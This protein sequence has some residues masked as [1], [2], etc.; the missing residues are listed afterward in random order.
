MTGSSSGGGDSDALQRQ[1]ASMRDQLQSQSKLFS[2]QMENGRKREEELRQQL[3]K[4]RQDSNKELGELRG[5]LARALENE[6]A[7]KV[8]SPQRTTTTSQSSRSFT[9]LS[10][11]SGL[12]L[13]GGPTRQVHGAAPPGVWVATDQHDPLPVSV[14]DAGM[15]V[16]PVGP[17]LKPG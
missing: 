1:L 2:D 16:P 10:A 4:I 7:Y 11:D 14:C 13:A 9:L 5:Q 6:N 3:V 17:Y 12:S 8:N 15:H